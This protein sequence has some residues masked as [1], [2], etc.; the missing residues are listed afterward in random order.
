[1][2]AAGEEDMVVLEEED[3]LEEG[4]LAA[5]EEDA[6]DDGAGAGEEGTFTLK[7]LTFIVITIKSTVLYR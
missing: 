3:V 4:T 7:L 1:M 6:V 5:R 2:D